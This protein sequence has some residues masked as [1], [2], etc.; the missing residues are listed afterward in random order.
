MLRIDH[1]AAFGARWLAAGAIVLALGC[2][3]NIS[4]GAVS[5]VTGDAD[6][7]S[8]EAMRLDIEQISSPETWAG[9]ESVDVCFRISISNA[10][11]EAMRVK[12]ITLQ[13]MGGGTYRLESSSRKFNQTIAPGA[14]ES[15]RYWASAVA[16]DPSVGTHG[17]LVVRTAVD[18][19]AES[20]PVHAVFN[21]RVNGMVVVTAGSGH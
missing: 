1:S 19:V 13:S 11:K 18:A 8:T 2:S 6:Y 20:V 9:N 5:A 10:T 21:R 3:G 4:N 12:R 16:S 14:K 7:D 17:P 15:F